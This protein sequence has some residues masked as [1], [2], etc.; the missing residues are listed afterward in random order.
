MGVVKLRTV[1]THNASINEV[2]ASF[3]VKRVKALNKTL[4]FI[5][6]IGHCSRDHL[7]DLRSKL[8]AEY[9]TFCVCVVCVTNNKN[10][11]D[12]TALSLTQRILSSFFLRVLLI[13]LAIVLADW[14]RL[15]KLAQT[16]C[17]EPLII[18]QLDSVLAVLD[19]RLDFI[20]MRG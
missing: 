20:W 3:P 13:H 4:Q 11:A 1:G 2:S 14:A 19:E 12:V 7:H 17:N 10:V 8:K 16:F 15:A 5:F 18:R 6:L 9:L